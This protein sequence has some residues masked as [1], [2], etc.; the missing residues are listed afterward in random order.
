MK[1]F[2]FS[3]R[4]DFEVF[5]SAFKF[6]FLI[7]LKRLFIV[8]LFVFYYYIFVFG[9]VMLTDSIDASKIE[10]RMKKIV[11]DIADSFKESYS[12]D[13]I[14]KYPIPSKDRI[15]GILKD[16][17]DI[18]FPGYFTDKEINNLN[19]SF[20]LGNKINKIFE[21]LSGE[22]TKSYRHEHFIKNNSCDLCKGCSD[23]CVENGVESALFLLENIPE[24][25]RKLFFDVRASYDGDPAAKGYNEI[26]YSYP[27]LFAITIHRIANLLYKKNVPLIPRIMSEYSHSSTGIDIH[28]G[29]EIGE[30]IFIDH[31]TGVVIGETCNI[32]SGVK[33]YQGVTLGA[34]SFKKDEKGKIIKGQKRHP[35]IEDCVTIYSGATIL[36]GETVI[37]KNSV[38]GGNVWIT[39]S[40]P[41]NSKVILSDTQTKVICQG[42]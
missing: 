37:G 26:I 3:K 19:L 1:C 38:I 40:V 39:N 20:Y 22:I 12:L 36:G 32:G 33:I 30:S 28:P 24:I 18:L 13:H 42:V 5:K 10:K 21:E 23:L 8:D 35:T 16:V 25:R 29:S 31:G 7:M 6:F 2:E 41:P 14:A 4:L 27:G 11:S 15:I 17:I 9:G 34:L